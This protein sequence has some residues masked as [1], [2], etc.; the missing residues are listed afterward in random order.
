MKDRLYKVIELKSGGSIRRFSAD[1]G[2][3]YDNIYNYYRKG[4]RAGDKVSAE[5]IAKTIL[6][7]TDISA[8]WLLT[9]RGEMLLTNDD[10]K[11]LRDKIEDAKEEI[12]YYKGVL[13]AHGISV[14][15]WKKE[16]SA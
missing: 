4:K 1:I 13:S 6:E 12:G 11:M 9:G 15:P 5:V 14:D 2:L 8:D 16:R 10:N 3:P 7:F